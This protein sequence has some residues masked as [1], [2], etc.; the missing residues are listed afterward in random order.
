MMNK[1]AFPISITKEKLISLRS[2]LSDLEDLI[3]ER[4]DSFKEHLLKAFKIKNFY[5]SFS[6]EEIEV[7][8]L[9]NN[10]SEYFNKSISW[11]NFIDW[12]YKESILKK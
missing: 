12:L 11:H 6:D 2:L 5:I 4:E 7:N 8:F 1:E 9:D 10:S 3:R